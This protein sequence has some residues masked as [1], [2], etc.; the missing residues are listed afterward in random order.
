MVSD[1]I[2]GPQSPGCQVKLPIA[3]TGPTSA[4][5]GKSICSKYIPLMGSTMTQLSS[6]S[7]IRVHPRRLPGCATRCRQSYHALPCQ[8]LCTPAVPEA[9]GDHQKVPVPTIHLRSIPHCHPVPASSAAHA[10]FHLH[11]AHHHPGCG[12]GEREK[13]E[14]NHL[15]VA[16]Q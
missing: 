3:S 11:L 8:R 16:L 1:A 14:G 4:K 2:S 13:T 6:V 7:E 10:E 15:C 5:P 12:A 9:H